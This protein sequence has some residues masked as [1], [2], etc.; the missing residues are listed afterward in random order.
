M[1]VKRMPG[2]TRAKVEKPNQRKLFFINLLRIV[3]AVDVIMETGNAF[4]QQNMLT[5]NVNRRSLP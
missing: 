3:I 1:V 2:S 4:L 5:E